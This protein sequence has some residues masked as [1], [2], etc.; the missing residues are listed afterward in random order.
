MDSS[1]LSDKLRPYI[2]LYLEVVFNSPIK[3]DN[4]TIL[5]YDVVVNKLN[6]ETVE[7]FNG[8]GLTGDNFVSTICLL[9][10]FRHVAHFLNYYF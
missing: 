5:P 9:I 3:L 10:L 6:E 1:A 7:H 8:C 4:G 2:E